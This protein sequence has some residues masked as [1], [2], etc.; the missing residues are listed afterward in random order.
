MRILYAT[1]R[2]HIPD[3]V[4]GALYAAHSLLTILSRRGHSCE[5]IASVGKHQ[6][7]RIFAYRVVRALSQRRVLAVADRRTGYP[8][9]RSWESLVCA[10]VRQRIRDFRPEVLLTQLDGSEAIARIGIEHGIP[11]LVWVHDNEFCFFKGNVPDS[12]LLLTLSATDFVSREMS[13]RLACYS[14]VLYPPVQLDRCRATRTQPHSVTL[15]N[16]VKEKG[17]AIALEVARMLPHRHFLFVE[18]WPLRG[19]ALQGLTSA[20]TDLPNVTFRRWSKEISPVYAR[21]EILLAPS[22]WVEAFCTVVLE[23]HVNGIPVIASRIG[24]I[25]TT[26][27]KGGILLEPDAPPER[28]AAAVEDLLSDKAAYARLS[29][30]A[31]DNAAREEFNPDRIVDRFLEIASDHAGRARRLPLSTVMSRQIVEK[32]A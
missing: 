10:T 7:A 24:G 25:P 28:W 32:S 8:T 14:P 1:W 15:I 2:A 19:E 12:P 31:L 23:A 11:T 22:Q 26:L 9:R 16:P 13:K 17:V 6:P 30:I 29:R 3:R 5:A 18:T 4:D 20:L 27:G 21:T